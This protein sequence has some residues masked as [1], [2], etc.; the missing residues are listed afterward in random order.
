MVF[1]FNFQKS[2]IGVAQGRKAAIAQAIIVKWI[3]VKPVP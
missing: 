3:L 1:A 2:E